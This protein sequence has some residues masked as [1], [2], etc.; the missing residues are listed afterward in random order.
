M[1][2]ID[3]ILKEIKNPGRYI[4]EEFNVIKKSWS[5]TKLHVA[6]AFPDLYEI[7][8]SNLGFQI[9][10][11]LFNK[12]EDTLCE[13]VFVPD[14][15]M[16]KNLRYHKIPIFTLE[17][18]TPLFKFDWIG[19]SIS[20]E[21]NYSGVLNILNLSDIPIFSNQRKNND[22]LIIAGGPSVLN[23]EPLAPFID[24]FFIGEAE[25]AID[26]LVNVYLEWKESKESRLELYKR[27]VKIEGIYIPFLYEDNSLTPKYSWVPEKINRRIV[28]DLNKAYF[29]VKP[30]V[31]FQSTVHDR[32]IVEIMRGCQRNCRFCFAG[33]IYRPKRI[34]EPEKIKE[35]IREVFRNTGYEEISLLSLS[36]NDY[37]YIE[38]LIQELNK[39]FSAKYLSFS[40]SSLRADRFSLELA[41]K[42]Q[43]V[44]KSGLT[45]AIEAGTERLR[46]V[47]NKGLKDEDLLNTIRNAYE[48]GWKRIKLYFM[49]GLPTEKE[50]DIEDLIKLVLK[51]KNQNKGIILHL[52]FSIFIPK[53]HTVFQ[54]EKFE[55]K[56]VV[57]KRKKY[58]LEKLRKGGFIIDFHD[59]NMSLLEAIFSRGDR[60]LSQVLFS[61]WE[62]GSR[63][64]GWK[65]YLNISI[66]EEAFKNNKID[67]WEYLKE[68]DYDEV[69]PWDHILTGVSK[70]FLKR[71][72]EKAYK[73]EETPPCEWGQYC[74]FCGII[75]HE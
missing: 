41:E 5:N 57:E 42:L 49:L 72:R 15:D 40:L 54:W 12:R 33:Y 64:E 56:E 17:S 50:E 29:P 66:W 6:L 28:K 68:K 37:P 30:L 61:A 44:R 58:I 52:G 11:H 47:I 22:P 71:E 67:P 27:L 48:M 65:D 23:P 1:D 21:L 39:E 38:Y 10:Y 16:E 25:D 70:E 9:V 19:F 20:Y 4:G 63:L 35:I 74:E 34:R 32:G 46:R 26:E 2:R 36:S 31:P 59:Y 7:G 43:S 18:R 3:S 53:P 14:L 51:I 13:R 24:I 73:E 62:K 8:M 69:L 75:H 45:F 55:R 60:K